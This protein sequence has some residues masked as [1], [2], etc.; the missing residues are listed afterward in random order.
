[1]RIVIIGSNGQIGRTLQ[2]KLV[3]HDQFTIIAFNHDQLD[4]TNQQ[5]LMAQLNQTAA[6]LVINAA[7]YNSVE[8][9]ETERTA[10]FAV[11]CD[12][13]GYLS[14]YCA[15]AHIPMIHLSTDYIFDGRRDHSY[16]ERCLPAPLNVYGQSKLAGEKQ[17]AE[18]LTQHII[19]RLSAVFSPWRHNFVKTVLNLARS[20]NE[21]PIVDDQI[22]CP[23]AADD[24]AELIGHLAIAIAQGNCH[25]G[26]YHYCSREPTSWYDFAC[27]IISTAKQR[28]GMDNWAKIIPIHSAQFSQQA[29]RPAYSVLNCEKLQQTFAITL[30]RWQQSLARVIGTLSVETLA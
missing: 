14:D 18:R 11:N 20:Q 4:I 24:I 5:M 27:A 12:G 9:A 30:P 19:L 16:D 3:A 2:H 10:A 29:T 15:Q 23:T 13:V 25:W 8:H 1:M 28:F 7:A 26:C 6:D 22:T 21:L 17:L